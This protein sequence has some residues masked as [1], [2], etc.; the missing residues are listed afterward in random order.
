LRFS[1]ATIPKSDSALVPATTAFTAHYG[2]TRDCLMTPTTKL[3]EASAATAIAGILVTKAGTIK[4]SLDIAL[5]KRSND[6]SIVVVVV[7]LI[8][9]VKKKH[10]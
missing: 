2:W 9:P 7:E 8:R 1:L 3:L 6:N 5:W 10:A 4:F